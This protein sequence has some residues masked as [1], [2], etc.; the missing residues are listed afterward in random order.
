MA[1]HRLEWTP[2]FNVQATQ[3]KNRQGWFVG[4]LVRWRYGLLQKVA[5]WKQLFSTAAAGIVRALHAYEDLLDNVNLLMPGD[6]GA[7]IYV[8]GTLYTF[9]F[10]QGTAAA[11]G[12]TEMQVLSGQRQVTVAQGNQPPGLI[13]GDTV[14]VLCTMSIGGQIFHPGHTFTITGVTP[15]SEYTFNLPSNAT[16]N[17]LAVIP[18]PLFQNQSY[19]TVNVTLENHG[20]STGNSFTFDVLTS[21]N[22]SFHSTFNSLNIPA[23][24][25]AIVTVIDTNTFSFDASPFG[26]FN[27]TLASYYEGTIANNQGNQPFSPTLAY[28]GAAPSPP[29]SAWFVDNFGTYGLVCYTGGPLWIY[30]P[31]ISSGA[32][33]NNAG[34]PDP[35]ITGS[36]APQINTGAFVAMPQ[37]QIIAFG[38]EV[39]L[40]GGQQDPL[41]IRFSDAGNFNSWTASATNQAGSFHLGGSGTKIIG[42][43]QA[44]QTSLIW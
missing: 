13:V 1:L 31:P 37:A 4:N 3:T 9:T 28:A 44:P 42:G 32:V 26:F 36:G 27:N 35:N 6:G 39:I 34:I 10:N 38:S 41:L 21:I 11:D 43:I 40:G 25:T 19:P 23:G 5:G 20:L 22:V 15:F 29:P 18:W 24:S 14:E 8:G 12:T 30:T 16:V 7:Q 33:L 2:G 17:D